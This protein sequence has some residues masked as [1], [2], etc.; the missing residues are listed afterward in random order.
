MSPSRLIT[1]SLG[2]LGGGLLFGLLREPAGAARAVRPPSTIDRGFEVAPVE[3]DLRG[4]NRRLV[5]QGSY[6]VNI[7]AGCND[8]HTNPP[9]RPGGN[10]HLGEPKQIN[11]ENYMAGG[12]AFGPQIV[13]SNI[14]P[15]AN[16]LPAGHNYPQFLG[17]MRTGNNHHRPGDVLQVMPWPFYS[18]LTDIDLRS[19]YEYLRSIPHAEPAPAPAVGKG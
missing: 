6:L 3:L 1:L 12:L 17:Q 5:G 16:G 10:P 7:M 14:T 19:I 4:K 13:S 8:C 15:D 11:T 2:L 9:Y 18:R